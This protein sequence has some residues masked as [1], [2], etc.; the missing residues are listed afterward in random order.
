MHLELSNYEWFLDG[1]LSTSVFLDLGFECNVNRFGIIDMEMVDVTCTA[2]T[3]A[4]R[5]SELILDGAWKDVSIPGQLRSWFE[6]RFRDAWNGSAELRQ[7]IQERMN[8]QAIDRYFERK[9]DTYRK[10]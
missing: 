3:F 10:V 2:I 8:D 9:T 7:E 4:M 6:S 1:D 5:K